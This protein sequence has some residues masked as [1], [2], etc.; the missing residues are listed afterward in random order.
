MRA[1]ALGTN[2]DKINEMIDNVQS[3]PGQ[4]FL[5]CLSLCAVFYVAVK[6]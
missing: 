3:S 6:H 4:G 5:H 1:G 2:V